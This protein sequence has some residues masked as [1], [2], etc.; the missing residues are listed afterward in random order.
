MT[1]LLIKFSELFLGVI[2][3]IDDIRGRPG[4]GG[5]GVTRLNG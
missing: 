5:R 3:C 2:V 4:S 1:I